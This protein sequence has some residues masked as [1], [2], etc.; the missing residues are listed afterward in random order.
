VRLKSSG[1]SPIFSS[2]CPAPS[3]R[4]QGLLALTIPRLPEKIRAR[5][6][7]IPMKRLFIAVVPLVAVGMIRAQAPAEKPAAPS[8]VAFKL[9]VADESAKS[10][11]QDE[12]NLLING[13]FDEGTKGWG[14]FNWGKKS[15]ME[16]DEEELHDGRPTLRVENLESCHSYVR[17]IIHAKPNTRYRLTGYIKTGHIEPAKPGQRV[18]AV[19][20]IG[21]RGIFTAPLMEE[22]MPW[23]KVTVDFSTT[24]TGEIRVGPSFGYPGFITGT[25]WFADL[26]LVEVDE[27]D[28]N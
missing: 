28:K 14:F 11:E 5:F 17:Q 20:E 27:D 7:P 8:T 12:P 22:N 23:T 16:M 9:A 18:G 21:T 3:T 4:N 10:S 15:K 24:E 2:G 19:L 26:S 6:G 1:P 25:A 13:N